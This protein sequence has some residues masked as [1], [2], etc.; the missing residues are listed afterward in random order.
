[1]AINYAGKN[2]IGNIDTY[3]EFKNNKYIEIDAEY[4]TFDCIKH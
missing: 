1:M 2:Y 4:L 3:Y